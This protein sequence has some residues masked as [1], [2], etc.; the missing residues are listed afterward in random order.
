[1]FNDELRGRFTNEA[2]NLSEV[3]LN[4]WAEKRNLDL[5]YEQYRQYKKRRIEEYFAGY[6]L[7]DYE[8][9]IEQCVEIRKYLELA[10]IG[11][12]PACRWARVARLFG[13][14][15]AALETRSRCRP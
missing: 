5:D 3:L 1:M 2:Y 12:V 10:P 11:S 13:K 14:V 7:D 4:D 15:T 9:L 6:D 8:R